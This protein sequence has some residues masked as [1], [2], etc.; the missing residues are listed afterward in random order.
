MGLT[1]PKT[2]VGLTGG[3][4]CGKSTA[5]QEFAKLGWAVVS[6]DS[7]ASEILNTDESVKRQIEHRWGKGVMHRCGS[8]DKTAVGR[9]VFSTEQERSWIESLLHPIIRSKWLSFIQSCPSQKCMVEL[10]LLFENKLQKNFSCTITTYA[11]KSV[12]L[13]RLTYRGFSPKESNARLHSQLPLDEKV[14]LSDY[15]LWG[16]GNSPFLSLQVEHLDYVLS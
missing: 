10:P 1:S 3:I 15:I 4:A 12:I 7:L 9:I 2:V 13:K 11:P 5:L 14:Q 16:G 8:V 6:T